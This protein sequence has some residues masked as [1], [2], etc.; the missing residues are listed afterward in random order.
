[1]FIVTMNKKD[2]QEIVRQSY[3]KART[4]DEWQAL[5]EMDIASLGDT[6]AK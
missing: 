1:M 3:K 4:D 6:T 2:A 5:A